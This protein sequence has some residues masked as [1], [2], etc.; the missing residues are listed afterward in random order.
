MF[1]KSIRYLSLFG[2]MIVLTA[3]I[4]SQSF[5]GNS[6]QASSQN[7][8]SSSIY[9]PNQLRKK[10]NIIPIFVPSSDP[11]ANSNPVNVDWD[12]INRV[13]V[14]ARNNPTTRDNIDERYK[15]LQVLPK[16]LVRKGVNLNSYFPVSKM[17]DIVSLMTKKR[18]DEAAPK[19]YAAFHDL[20]AAERKLV[21]IIKM[22]DIVSI[23][24]AVE[25]YKPV[26]IS[27]LDAI[28]HPA[29]YKGRYIN[30]SGTVIKK[31]GSKYLV[32]VPDQSSFYINIVNP[33]QQ[34][35]VLTHQ[36]MVTVIGKITDLDNYRT[37][38]GIDKNI[39]NID[40]AYVE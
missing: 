23:D 29:D 37:S 33:R 39:I 8:S 7:R 15:V 11:D 4:N 20:D 12:T 10:R 35:H 34:N 26:A 6:N 28:H 32:T 14:D 17:D 36:Q 9:I 38:L 27:L 3:G 2:C 19:I 31:S 40:V 18:Y 25:A 24:M 13:R 21:K 16:L 30:W 5:F 1:N 22:E